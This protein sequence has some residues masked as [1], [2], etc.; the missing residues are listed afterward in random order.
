MARNALRRPRACVGRLRSA[1]C[2]Q[3]CGSDSVLVARAR[4]HPGVVRWLPWICPL[5]SPI[6]VCYRDLVIEPRI[7]EMRIGWRVPFL[8]QRAV[9]EGLGFYSTPL[10]AGTQG[11]VDR[12]MSHLL[13]HM[14]D[15]SLR[16]IN[17]DVAHCDVLW[18]PQTRG[19]LRN[20]DEPRWR[21][22]LVHP[23]V[24]NRVRKLGDV[25]LWLT[26]TQAAIYLLR[27]RTSA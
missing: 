9:P 22:R 27:Y 16:F 8:V 2:S 5:D 11:Q 23:F 7:T 13:R 10:P 19:Q 6:Y 26:K 14:P 20:H 21:C 12:A 25:H 18:P 1:Q 24:S 17:L 4:T 3:R 15:L